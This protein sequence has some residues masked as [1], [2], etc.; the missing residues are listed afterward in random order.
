MTQQ[1][2]KLFTFLIQSQAP[3]V[4]FSPHCPPAH[5]EPGPPHYRGF[6]IALRHATFGRTSLEVIGPTHRP[7]PHN[8]PH[9]QQTDIHATGRIRTRNLSKCVTADPQLRMRGH[10]VRQ[11]CLLTFCDYKLF[12]SDLL[13]SSRVTERNEI[14]MLTVVNFCMLQPKL[15]ILWSHV[16]TKEYSLWI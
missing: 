13:P 11:M 1:T 10:Q 4:P 14:C 2:L 7:L 12:N 16:I 8:P 15:G 6:E 3:P 5:S 9:S